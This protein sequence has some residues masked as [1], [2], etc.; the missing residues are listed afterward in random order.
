CVYWYG[1]AGRDE[2][3]VEQAVIRFVKPGEE[4]TS[5]TFVNR[6]LAFMFANTKSFE[7]LLMLPKVAF[8]M[9]CNDQ[10]CVNIKHISAEG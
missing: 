6:L 1:E 7:R 5:E 9:T 8:K 2:K 3:S 4:E 10:L